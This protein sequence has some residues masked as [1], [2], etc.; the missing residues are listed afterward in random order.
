MHCMR[1]G[2]YFYYYDIILGNCIKRGRAYVHAYK[3]DCAIDIETPE[4]IVPPKP[5]APLVDPPQPDILQ[6]IIN[7]EQTVIIL[8][9]SDG[10]PYKM[11]PQQ[12]DMF[13]E[14]GA[15]LVIDF[16]KIDDP[17]VP[18]DVDFVTSTP[19]HTLSYGYTGELYWMYYRGHV[20]LGKRTRHMQGV[21]MAMAD[22][23]NVPIS[24]LYEADFKASQHPVP[25]DVPMH[26]I[27]ASDVLGSLAEPFRL[28]QNHDE[29]LTLIYK[30]RE[31][32]HQFRAVLAG[33]VIAT[34]VLQKG[35]HT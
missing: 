31:I 8:E 22:I 17:D 21:M 13:G 33:Y 26:K 2:V 19:H 32:T 28:R 5:V 35:T 34:R 30:D 27:V 3:E 16:D 4:P 23:D 9:K 25:L 14:I 10:I 12:L 15:Q 1:C 6:P 7:P 29:T 24:V 18:I 11:V 20:F